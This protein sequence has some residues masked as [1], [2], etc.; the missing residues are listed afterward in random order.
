MSAFQLSLYQTTAMKLL[1]ATFFGSIF[2]FLGVALG[3]L[4]SHALSGKITEE[5]LKSYMISIRYMLFHGIVLLFLSALPFI[6]APKKE[7]LALLL[8]IGVVV[9]SGSILLLSTKAIHGLNISWL[10]PVTPIGGLLLLGA[11][12]YVCFLLGKEIFA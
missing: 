4:G 3:A 8:V 12:A 11:W 9:F 2:M 6:E 10:G 1:T 5:A 7:R